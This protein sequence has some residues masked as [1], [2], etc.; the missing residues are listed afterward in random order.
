MALNAS[1]HIKT[2]LRGGKTVLEKAYC[3]PPFKIANIT[4]DRNARPLQLVL[5]S[6]SPGLLDGDVYNMQVEIGAGC[7]LQLNTQ[8]YQRLFHMKAQARQQFDIRMEP[9]S[10]FVY[11]P[12][13][14]VPHEGSRYIGRN[15]IYMSGQCSLVW[16]EIFSC[17]RKLNGEVF[18]FTQFHARTDIYLHGRLVVKENFLLNPSKTDALSMGQFEGYTHQ[19]T[20]ICI[21]ETMAVE[22]ACAFWATRQNSC[23]RA[24]GKWLR[25]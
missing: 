3:T 21:N 10:S 5:M 16:S 7:A 13:P 25:K 4:E 23:L 18:R 14:S 9:G 6:S 8:S 24:S 19:A 22:E 11:L 12:H 17:G 2:A 1:L 20:M 15:N